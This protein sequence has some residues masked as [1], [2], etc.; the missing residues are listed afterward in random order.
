VS[1]RS[2]AQLRK[3][4]GLGALVLGAGVLGGCT[5]PTFGAYRGATT[6]A[7]D[8]FTLWSWMCIAGLAVMVLVL[9]LIIW[10]CF[11]YRRRNDEIPHQFHSNI[12][13]EILYTA[14]PLIMVGVIFGYTVVVENKIDTV[15][16]TPAVIIRVTGFQWGWKFQYLPPDKPA[17]LPIA[18]V[19]TAAEPKVLA[20][21][22][23]SPDYPQF[24]LPIGVTTRIVLVSNDVVHTFYIP[25]FNFGRYALPGVV[26]T[27]D[28]TPTNFGAFPGKCAQYCGLYH[29]EML[30]SVRVVSMANYR[31]WLAAHA[32]A[33]GLTAAA[34]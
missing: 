28:F 5:L 23:L 24:V 11:R 31:V 27:F 1:R 21:N 14:I 20:G 15:S 10:A 9:G 29:S 8:E 18:S 6:Q 34:G 4:V 16:P 7:Q 26:N 3:V 22:P 17:G 12:A 2:P 30:F 25:E 19:V 32:T 33:P 13:I